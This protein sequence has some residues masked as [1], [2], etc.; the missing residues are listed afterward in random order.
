MLR[1]VAQ[2]S[3]RCRGFEVV[4]FDVEQVFDERLCDMCIAEYE[5][6]H[7]RVGD[8]EVIKRLDAHLYAPVNFLRLANRRCLYSVELRFTNLLMT[9]Q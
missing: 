3:F 8:V 7:N 4:Y 5:S 2:H 1:I 6:E 9:D